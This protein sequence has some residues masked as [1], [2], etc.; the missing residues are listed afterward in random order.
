MAKKNAVTAISLKDCMQP[1]MRGND[2]KNL[3]VEVSNGAASPREIGESEC[4]AQHY[5]ILS[6]FFVSGEA[7]SVGRAQNY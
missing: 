4:A 2:E 1:T 7:T 6:T 5:R 3:E